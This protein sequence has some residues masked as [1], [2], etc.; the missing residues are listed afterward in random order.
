MD[1]P[2]A[3]AG[4]TLGHRAGRP[5]RTRGTGPWLRR[6]ERAADRASGRGCRREGGPSQPTT[7]ASMI[8]RAISGS[9][10]RFRVVPRPIPTVSLPDVDDRAT[11]VPRARVVPACPHAAGN[12]RG[13]RPGSGRLVGHGEPRAQR[14]GARAVSDATRSRVIAAADRL[15]YVPNAAAAALRAGRTSSSWSVCPRGPRSARGRGDLVARQRTRAA[16]L[17]AAG[18]HGSRRRSGRSASACERARPVGVIALSEDLTSEGRTGCGVTARARSSD[19][20][21]TRSRACPR[22]CSTRHRS[23]GPRW[24]IS[25]LE[26]TTGSWR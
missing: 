14:R 6:F 19:P 7:R 1:E 4:S 2:S 12:E 16:R 21:G 5:A 18:A 24:T 13:C 20:R 15:G 3:A 22:S 10:R 8:A 17:H 9:A 25:P 23:V 11:V 26:D